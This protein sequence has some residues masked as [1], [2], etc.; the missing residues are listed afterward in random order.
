MSTIITRSTGANPKG[1]PLTAGEVD[2][3]FI[4]LNADKVESTR[5]IN[6]TT[7][8]LTGGGDLSGDRT[9]GLASTGITAGTI[10]NSTTQLTPTTLDAKGRVVEV[11][12]PQ[13]IT[14]AFSSV[15]NKPTTLAGYGITDAQ[16]A[17][18]GAAT[19]IDTEDLTAS[20]VL[21]SD[22]SG[23]VGASA[24][25]VTTLG[26]LDASSSVQNQLD[27][28]QST[29]TKNQANGYAGLDSN[30]KLS[31]AVLPDLAVTEYLGEVA[32]EAAML[33]LTGES[34]DWCTRTDSGT[35]FVITGNPATVGG[36]M[37]LSYPGT[38]VKSVAG[39]TGIVTLTKTDVGL[40]NVNNTSDADK[41]IST[42]ALSALNNKQP[43]DAELTALAGLISAAN[44]LP[45]FTGSETAGLTDLSAFGRS[46]IDD[47]DAAAARV[48]L[49]LVPGTDV[50]PYD[51][52]IPTVSASQAE[53][54][55]G[56]ETALRSMSPLRIKQA[57]TAMAGASIAAN[58][59]GTAGAA[60]FG[61]GI[62]PQDQLPYGF[63]PL[64]GA[65]NPLSDNYG[66]YQYLDGSI[67][68]W[69]PAFYYKWGTGSNGLSVN[70][71]DIK[72]Y[73]AYADV[74]TANAAGYALHRAFYDGGA[75][76]AGFFVDKFQCSNNGGVASSIKMG[77]PLSSNSAH[78]PFSGLTGTPTNAY[79]GALAAAK[80]RGAQ[81]FCN[82]RFIHAALAL[83]SY[84][85]AQ[86]SSS[87]TYCAWYGSTTNYPKGNNNNALRDT[88]DT[89]VIWVSDGYSNAGKTGSAGY[90]GGAGN[91]FAKSTHNGQNCGVADLNGNMWEINLG[92]TSDG[93]NLYIMNTAVAMKDVTSGTTLATDA[94]GATGIAAM[95][96]SLGTT[97]ES[98]T[99]ANGWV[100]FGSSNQ[101]LVEA[102]S[103]N[104]W[105]LTGAGL[106]K[107][108]G[109]GGSNAFGQDGNYQPA[110]WPNELCPISGGY[111]AYGSY[112]GVW[113]FYLA[114]VRGHSY[115]YVGF[116]SASYP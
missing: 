61:V 58:V 5:A 86:A 49:G 60:G 116:R 45:Y 48:T 12:A 107:S 108:G 7:G 19:T 109:T 97:Y 42:A 54:E 10:N 39:K 74:A 77:N 21:V 102:T 52:D 6:T 67:M 79:H 90:A 81:F 3:N 28:K 46:I 23:K 4:N 69:V 47:A 110:A 93:T 111:W 84:A 104:G 26:Y 24:V 114:F 16:P 34:G 78:N 88:N 57:I 91:V 76:K 13:T 27:G 94:W 68:C 40:A 44:K 8:D 100:L 75:V 29:A 1:A 30:G 31:D 43:L 35:V 65:T 83:L 33:A 98:L 53:M 85:H 64:D 36:W 32:T 73:S 9:L 55:A 105:A 22:A 89:S 20:K 82:S 14:P 50:Q 41:P 59:I 70:V 51:A 113:A 87:T 112:A 38:P 56:T 99:K 101:V 37:Q 71:V 18:T 106:P 92:M 62:C 15:T 80:T 17:I 95:Y 25:S 96:T 103:G 66:N 115:A 72:A 11:G 63:V 2:Q